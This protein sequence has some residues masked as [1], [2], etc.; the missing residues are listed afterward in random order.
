VNDPWLVYAWIAAAL[1][2]FASALTLWNLVFWPRGR[3]MEAALADASILIPARNEIASIESS[4]RAALAA[5]PLEVVVYDDGS[6]DGTSDVLAAL[7][8]ADERLRVVAGH[9]LPEG[10]VGKPHACHQLSTHARGTWLLFVDADVALAPDALHRLRG[11]AEDYGAAAVTAV[12]RQETRSFA[13]RLIL[14][15]LHLTYTS[16]LPLPLIWRTHDPRFLAAN[17]QILAVTRAA[18]DA[19][20]GFAGVRNEVVDDMAFCRQLKLGRHRVVFADGFHLASCRMYGNA[21][22]VWKGF[23]KNLYEGI[24]GSLFA[25]LAVVSLYVTAFVAPFG[26]LAGA[27][28][29][30]ALLVP[31]AIA[32]AANL[33]LRGALTLRF[34]QPLESA[35]LHPV[36]TLALMAIAVNSAIWTYRGRVEW[37]GRIYAG[38]SRRVG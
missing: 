33:V 22:E 29:A 26:L 11:L 27:L 16:W 8:A 6:T 1:A 10:W 19:V 30:P 12:P 32:V 28:L 21:R 34:R 18:Y 23:S 20:G 36:G 31:A 5:G 7:A 4:V 38:R 3:R 25:L 24:G 15:L 17:G 37:A 35:L 2:T 9:G 13:E 14:P